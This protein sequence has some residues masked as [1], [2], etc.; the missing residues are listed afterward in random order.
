MPFVTGVS[1]A[2]GGQPHPSGASLGM[3]AVIARRS[4]LLVLHR[5]TLVAG[6]A[7]DV[8]ERRDDRA[9]AAD[10]E[11]ATPVAVAVDPASRHLVAE[12]GARYVREGEALVPSSEVVDLRPVE[13]G[14]AGLRRVEQADPTT[15]RRERAVDHRSDR[16]DAGAVRDED[17]LG[18]GRV[19]EDE[20]SP[21]AGEVDGRTLLEPEEIRRARSARD[22]VQAD[23]HQLPVRV[24]RDRV[25]TDQPLAPA[26]DQARDELPRPERDALAVRL[27]EEERAGIGVVR[28]DALDARAVLGRHRYI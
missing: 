15:R 5:A 10:E 14:R 21:R 3:R 12:R 13:D 24:R 11:A 23:L 7:E 17:R 9:D 16:R 28:Y 4:P 22:A 18:I 8:A 26:R 1:G 20:G 6:A 19:V 27:A 25:R 2:V